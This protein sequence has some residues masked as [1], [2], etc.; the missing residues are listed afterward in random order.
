MIS[1]T[2]IHNLEKAAKD[3]SPELFQI[4]I[5]TFGFVS[6]LVFIYTFFYQNG[7]NNIISYK[8]D[9]KVEKKY[10]DKYFEDYSRI[11]GQ[12]SSQLSRTENYYFRLITD[13]KWI[14]YNFYVSYSLL[15]YF[16]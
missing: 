9:E 7:K 4:I 13:I 15:Y 5:T 6:Q 14:K 16:H 12:F 1:E 8:I 2:I 10:I 3:F 11:L